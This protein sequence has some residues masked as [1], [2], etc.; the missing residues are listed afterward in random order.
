MLSSSCIIGPF[1]CCVSHYCTCIIYLG[2]SNKKYI[3]IV[4]KIEIKNPDITAED[5]IIVYAK[6]SFW[7]RQ[8]LETKTTITRL[9]KIAGRLNNK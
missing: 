1:L 4:M 9:Y 8:N 6:H 2:Y 5:N 3:Y 7:T